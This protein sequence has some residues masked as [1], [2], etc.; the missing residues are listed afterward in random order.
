M[1]PEAQRGEKVESILPSGSVYSHKGKFAFVNRQVDPKTR[2]IQI[3][4][5][6]RNPEFTLRPGQ[7]AT[8][9]AEIGS[10]P[11]ALPETR[12]CKELPPLANRSRTSS[13]RPQEWK[14]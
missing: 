3:A 8:A 1:V 7:Y 10:I 11:N 14:E 2:T 6:F 13:E 9:R 5:S 12:H 4:V